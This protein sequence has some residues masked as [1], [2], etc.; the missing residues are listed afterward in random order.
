MERAF[1]GRRRRSNEVASW[2]GE[3]RED[4]KV[5]LIEIELK[6]Y[7]VKVAALQET[8]WFGS[9][10]CQVGGS[11]VMTAGR[12]KSSWSDDM[13]RG[14]GVAIV[15]LGLVIDS[16]KRALKQS[17]AWGPRALS[18]C[19]LEGEGTKTKFHVVLCY[20][21]MRAASRQVKDAFYQDLGSILAAIP[22]GEKYVILGDF[23]AHVGS[24]ECV[25]DRWGSVRR[26]NG[27]GFIKD[28]GKYLLS[29]S[30]SLSPPGHC[31]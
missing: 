27:Y 23:N 2:L 4:R 21:P 31:A 16:W 3:R 11:V 28:A 8:K 26:P 7:N 9:E 20:A 5:D 17:K 30:S 10:V 15:P 18:A 29:L 19:L 1:D 24:R 14:E 13:Q 22:I 25:G 12:E 6:R